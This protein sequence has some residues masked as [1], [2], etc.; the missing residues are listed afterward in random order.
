MFLPQF[1]AA[2]VWRGRLRGQRT[3]LSWSLVLMTQDDFCQFFFFFLQN[4]KSLVVTLSPSII[5]SLFSRWW[6]REREREREERNCFVWRG[7]KKSWHFFLITSRRGLQ[8][9]TTIVPTAAYSNEIFIDKEIIQELQARLAR[10]TYSDLD[11]QKKYNKTQ[12]IRIHFELKRKNT[13]LLKK[14][15][16]K[17]KLMI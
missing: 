12:W 10:H 5:V 2:R 13:M 17:K 9:A 4:K 15:Y 1:I 11:L 8:R 16:M 7:G 14:I 3:S 6:E